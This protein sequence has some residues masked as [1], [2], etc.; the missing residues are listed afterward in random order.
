MVP[1]VWLSEARA[2]FRQHE[3]EKRAAQDPN[4][5]EHAPWG[6]SGASRFIRCPGSVKMSEAYPDDETVFAAEGTVAHF[7][8]EMCMEFGFELEDWLGS[9]IAQGSWVFDVD[10]EMVEAL[11]PGIEWCE[12]RPG[13]HVNEYQVRFDRWMP[14]QFGT[15][16]KGIITPDLITINDLKYGR[17]VP[18]QAEGNEQLQTY[19]L[20]F[21]DNVARHVTDAKEFLL[22]ID[23]PRV[24]GGGGEWRVTLDQLLEF[25]EKLRE[26][27]E[28]GNSDDPPLVPGEKQCR[29]CKAKADCAALAQWNLA[30]ME[31][32]L[33]DLDAEQFHVSD[34]HKFHPNRRAFVAKNYDLFKQWLDAVKARVLEDAMH[35]RETPGLKVVKGRKGRRAWV[36]EEKA[37]RFL[38]EFL[39]EDVIQSEPVLISPA[40]AEEKLPVEARERLGEFTSQSDGKPTLVDENDARPSISVG[41]ILDDDDLD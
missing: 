37:R 22:V 19:A 32:G 34:A 14:G 11:R 36:D 12:E 30:Q 29:F 5:P 39:T 41:D 6:A 31:L 16:D 35:G 2:W 26:A 1:E 15:L 7:V 38:N 27:Y 10:Q 18:V 4:E 40:V 23:Q 17:G 21:W 33:N 9:E 13:L 28:I 25:G 24:A 20:G 8:R 3:A